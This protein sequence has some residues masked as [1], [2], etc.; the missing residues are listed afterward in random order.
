MRRKSRG[1][2]MLKYVPVVDDT[3]KLTIYDHINNVSEVAELNY[4]LL[5]EWETF[6]KRYHSAYGGGSDDKASTKCILC[7]EEFHIEMYPEYESTT[8]LM[9]SKNPNH[10]IHTKNPDGIA[11]TTWEFCAVCGKKLGTDSAKLRGICSDDCQNRGKLVIETGKWNKFYPL[12]KL[13]KEDKNTRFPIFNHVLVS[14]YEN[15]MQCVMMKDFKWTE[16]IE[17]KGVKGN[18]SMAVR[19]NVFVDIMQS[20]NNED[21]EFSVDEEKSELY[22]DYKNSRTVFKG[23]SEKEY[24]EHRE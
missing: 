6:G 9:C 16:I 12:T 24:P 5:D 2:V 10:I 13:P 4:H 19:R 14:F 17:I 23:I 11:I 7:G 22:V 3:P 20:F 1:F 15:N 8:V 18:G 21:I